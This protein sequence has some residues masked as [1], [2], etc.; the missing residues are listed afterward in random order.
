MS[1]SGAKHIAF[2]IDEN[3]SFVLEAAKSGAVHDTIA[4]TLKLA[5]KAWPRLFEQPALGHVIETR[6]TRV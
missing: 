3:L 2:V 1:Q 6:I 5:S 4:I